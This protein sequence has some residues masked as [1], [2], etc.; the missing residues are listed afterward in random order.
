MRR[1]EET[2]DQPLGLPA[3]EILHNLGC[4]IRNDGQWIPTHA[5]VM[6]FDDDPQ[7]FISQA[8]VACVRFKGTDVMSY[9]DRRDL[10][11]PLYR[12]VDDA[13]QFIYRH[14]VGQGDKG[15]G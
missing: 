2:S 6:L 1:R 15:N 7:R 3:E 9:V 14:S 10:H 11:G 8:E 5:G 12:L 4:L 13:E